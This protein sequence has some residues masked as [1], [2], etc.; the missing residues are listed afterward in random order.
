M[1]GGVYRML[2]NERRT[3]MFSLCLPG[4]G[5][6]FLQ[7]LP[8]SADFCPEFILPAERGSTFGTAHPRSPAGTVY[9]AVQAELFLVKAVFEAFQTFLQGFP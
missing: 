9:L 3:G 2:T 1:K 8:D 5:T 7:L 6:G 4:Y